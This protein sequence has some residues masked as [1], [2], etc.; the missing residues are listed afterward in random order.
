MNL[1]W[2]RILFND[3][4]LSFLFEVFFRTTI[5]FIIILL[6]LRL[7]GKRGVKQISIF[8][9]VI[10]IALGSA[11]GD[12]MFYEDV[13]LVPALLVFVVIIF[14][15]RITTGLAAKSEA[16]ER[17][18]EGKPVYVIR[19]GKFSIR[20]FKKEGVSQDE[21]FSE[22]RMNNVEH[23]GQVKNALIETSGEISIF[24]YPDNEVKWGLP[25]LPDAFN[26]RSPLIVEQGVHACTFCGNPE[27]LNPGVSQCKVCNRKTWVKAIRTIRIS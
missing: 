24:Y 10:I 20:D 15:Y 12:P 16:F 8:E 6:A 2:E 14:L 13:G 25:L 5:M 21:F 22:L 4:P 23:L 3:L 27:E 7:S 19:E 9:M 26:C 18:I 1:E 11:A 17:L